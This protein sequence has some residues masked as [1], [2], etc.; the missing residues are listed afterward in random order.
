LDWT[1]EADFLRGG[2]RP[3]KR[4]LAVGLGFGS[5]FLGLGFGFVVVFFRLVF[6]GVF[7]GLVLG[8][9]LGL[10][11]RLVGVV[12]GG[13]AGGGSQGDD[14]D[15]GPHSEQEGTHGESPRIDGS[16]EEAT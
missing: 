8:G 13:E 6:V 3:L 15:G 1:R 10:G 5:L 2:A 14:G 12:G 11:L 16:M 7:V 9:L 4:V